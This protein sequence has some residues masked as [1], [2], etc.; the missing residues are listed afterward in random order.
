MQAQN[1]TQGSAKADAYHQC[2]TYHY[3]KAQVDDSGRSNLSLCLPSRSAIFC[4][5][6]GIHPQGLEA[7]AVLTWS[8]RI[9]S[10]GQEH[11]AAIT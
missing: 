2:W 3:I 4:V 5:D 7:A 6:F 10:I 11:E 8:S 1:Q 9:D